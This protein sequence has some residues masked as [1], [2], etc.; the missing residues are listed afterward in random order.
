MIDLG[1]GMG[2]WVGYLAA[3][4]LCL[5]ACSRSGLDELAFDGTGATAGGGNGARGGD[6]GS[7]GRAG[8]SG[9][10]GSGNTSTAGAGNAGFGGASDGGSGFGGTSQGGA[11]GGPFGAC[12]QDSD[13]PTTDSCMTA[14]CDRGFCIT[15]GRDRD[16]DGSIDAA[17]GGGDC[18]DLNPLAHPGAMEVCGDGADND[19][20]GVTDCSDPV[21]VGRANCACTPTGTEDCTNGVDDDCNGQLDCNDTAC[22]TSPACGCNPGTP[23]SCGNGLDDDCDGAIDCADSDCTGAPVCACH[24]LEQCGDGIDNDCDGLIDCADPGCS[25]FPSCVCAPPGKAE[26]CGNHMDDDCDGLVDCADTNCSGSPAC[27]LCK[28]EVCDNGLDDD[29]DGAIDCA[30]SN[31]RFEAN[32]APTP[33]IC[34][35]SVDDDRD[36]LADCNDPDCATN[37]VCVAKHS[38]CLS[39]LLITASGT[40][41]GNTLNNDS[42][43]EGTCGGA[44]PE[45]VFRLSLTQ[46]ANVQLD[47]IGSDFDTA[48]YVRAGSCGKGREIGCDD[49]GGGVARTS[50]LSLGTLQP[51][52]YFIFVDGFT[53]AM[54]LAGPDLGQYVLNVNLDAKPIEKC[55]NRIDDDGDGYVDCADSDCTT[56]AQCK[57]CNNGKNAVPELGIGACTN[58]I[59]DDCDGAVDCA[60]SDCNASKAYPTECCDGVDQNGNGIP[61]DFSCRC[62]TA[63]DCPD[64]EVCYQDTIGACGDPCRNFNGDI[65]V[66]AAPGSTC[67]A[68]SQQCEF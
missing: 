54:G 41:T 65:C 45:A 13:C 2:R 57:G 19:C 50:A 27:A 11:A 12:N 16:G 58:G 24:G 10:G 49:D 30:D 32:C 35:N 28:T 25:I 38:T 63:A 7:S 5:A 67:N 33:E 56:T 59:D 17:C 18:N 9:R 31:C 60:D 29:C 40:F 66:F 42:V 4:L 48:L 15:T 26:D 53:V 3:S 61:D 51:G 68:A 36:G 23:E 8:S 52:N 21:C 1:A 20:N 37:P 34:N 46:P 64:G 22:S 55:D 6:S 47:T 62:V 43:N 14:R 44:G 39:A